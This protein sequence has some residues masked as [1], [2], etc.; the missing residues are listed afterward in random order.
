MDIRENIFTTFREATNDNR[1]KLVQGYPT[2]I[3]LIGFPRTSKYIPGIIPG[4]QII[5][6]ASTGCGKSRL[7]RKL[8]VK[9]PLKYANQ[10]G[11]EIKIFLNSLEETTDKVAATLVAERLYAKHH[12]EFSF[13]DIMNYREDPLPDEEMNMIEEASRE[14]SEIYKNLNTVHIP[15]ITGFYKEVRDYMY[16]TGKVYKG[17]RGE[18]L[19]QVDFGTPWDVY[20]PDNP[21]RITIAISDTVDKYPGEHIRGEQMNQY[22]TIKYFSAYYSRQVLGMKMRVINCLVQQQVNNKEMIE[23]NFKGATI[24]EKLKPT[25]ATLAKCKATSED[26]TLGIGLFDPVKVGVTDYNGYEN[27]DN[28]PYSFRSL[29][30][31]KYREGELPPGAEIPLR[32]NFKIDEFKE[33]PPPDTI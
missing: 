29:S 5:V 20:I 33:L 9:D 31:L 1:N 4:E 22:D 24:V 19:K 6:T 3:P 8:L 26:C 32:C 18:A 13:Y 17:K 2:L 30:I 16:S 28:Q 21:A 14:C 7:T 25:L 23:T 27:L 15:S 11:L 12:R 10:K